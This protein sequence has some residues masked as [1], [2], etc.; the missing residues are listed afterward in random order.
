MADYE[1]YRRAQE[2][3]GYMQ[4]NLGYM[5]YRQW[6]RRRIFLIVG[7]LSILFLA[8]IV[9]ANVI[10]F[11]GV[12][13]F[14]DVSPTLQIALYS[15]VGLV[16]AAVALQLY[17]QGTGRLRGPRGPRGLE[18]E[19]SYSVREMFDVVGNMRKELDE[20]SKSQQL[21]KSAL[22]EEE[23]EN[24]VKSLKGRIE[25]AAQQE[26]LKELKEAV[27]EELEQKELSERAGVTIR[28][29]RQETEDLG[30]RG[31][32][33]L[34]LGITTTLAGLGV[35][36][37]VVFTTPV[38][39]ADPLNVL[40]YYIPRLTLVIFI[41]VFAYF[42]LRLYKSSLG[43]IKYFQNELTNVELKFVALHQAHQQQD[44]SVL[45]SILE[46]FAKTE[47]NFLLEN[48][49]TTVGLEKERISQQ[50]ILERVKAAP[51]LVRKRK[52]ETT[53]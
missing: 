23:R 25:K 22:T 13:P 26:L 49:Q 5:R 50:P 51:R 28:R 10:P 30:R 18:A 27:A 33:N 41:E 46:E 21:D 8:V 24:F 15:G 45:R 12:S 48:G 35:L 17:L 16:T 9:V 20:L 37:Y 1:E 43:E 40:G 39:V 29:L 2:N 31:N 36:A 32:L 3:L 19:I 52:K 6:R 11:S 34:V 14:A 53:N 42:F 38:D 47:R 4:E 7:F 44:D